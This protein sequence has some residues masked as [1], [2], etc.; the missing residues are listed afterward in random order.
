MLQRASVLFPKSIVYS[1]K[2]VTNMEDMEKWL[3]PDEHKI[4]NEKLLNRKSPRASFHDYSG[5]N[6]FITI[7]T[8][9]MISYFGKIRDGIMYFSE[10]GRIANDNLLNLATHYDYVDVPLFVVMP[11]HIH[12]V[13]SIID[14]PANSSNIIPSKR[15]ALGVVVGGYK[16]SVTVYARRNNIEFGW[17][18][19]YHDHIIRGVT[20]ANKIANYIENNVARWDADRFHSNE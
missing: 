2:I 7:C 20:D 12:A 17:H 10:I 15:S 18:G 4:V 13:I 9:N 11:N 16:Q 14:P 19:N 6:Y 8:Y 3:K 5:G 1:I